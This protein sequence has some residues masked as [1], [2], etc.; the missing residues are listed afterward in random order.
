MSETPLVVA[1]D[2]NETLSDMT[3]LAEQFTAA[4][5]PPD[6]SKAW[7]AS[8]LRDGFALATAGTQAP[9]S[10]I[11]ADA[12]RT[13]LHGRPDLTQSVED[14]VASVLDAFGRLDVHPDVSEGMR[15]LADNGVRLV[16]LTN[17]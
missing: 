10:D 13:L 12:L 2:V 6:L 15:D 9:F 1:F 17:G 3:P 14:V 16:T 4:G 11:A 5:L 7:F 8:T